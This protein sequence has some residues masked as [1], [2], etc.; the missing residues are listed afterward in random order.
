MAC[1]FIFF[2]SSVVAC[3]IKCGFAVGNRQF[4]D[5][6]HDDES[7]IVDST[8]RDIDTCGSENAKSTVYNVSGIHGFVFMV[9]N[10]DS[11]K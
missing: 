1:G 2:M 10:V 9:W 7:G 5:A 6:T 4:I 11:C 8:F 3:C